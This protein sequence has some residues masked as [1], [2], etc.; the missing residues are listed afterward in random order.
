M[1]VLLGLVG[2]FQRDSNLVMVY[3]LNLRYRNLVLGTWLSVL[4]T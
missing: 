4:T 1:C 2:D 3:S